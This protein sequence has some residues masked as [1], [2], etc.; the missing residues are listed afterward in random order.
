MKD[1]KDRLYCVACDK[2]ILPQGQ[3]SEQSV[4]EE[5]IESVKD[6]LD[7]SEKTFL[8][9]SI[10]HHSSVNNANI[11]NISSNGLNN[12]GDAEEANDIGLI[13][14]KDLYQAKRMFKESE[15]TEIPKALETAADETIWQLIIK[16][17]NA[18][19]DLKQMTNYSQLKEVCAFINECSASIES[20]ISLKNK[21][22]NCAFLS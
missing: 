2:F 8:E 10:D 14:D 11:Y 20:L 22:H 7:T 21:T 13:T 5:E 9:D 16:L 3:K 17:E 18:Q 12:R 4:G 6:V 1:K 19:N 15:R